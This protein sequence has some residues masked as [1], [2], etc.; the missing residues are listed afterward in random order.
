MF[1]DDINNPKFHKSNIDNK[2]TIATE[3]Q[4]TG[5]VG[6]MGNNQCTGTDT[7]SKKEMIREGYELLLNKGVKLI[8]IDG[9]MATTTWLDFLKNDK[10]KLMVVL[11]DFPTVEDN[12]ERVIQR[13]IKKKPKDELK[14][15]ESIT[16]KT[17]A[18]L[19]GKIKGFRS[20]YN[21]VI[22]Y[23]DAVL[24]LEFNDPDLSSKISNTIIQLLE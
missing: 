18:N 22:P 15:I 19:E 7:I 21:K 20:L 6:A 11:L 1:N 17:M 4:I 5:H 2:T 24:K 10:S 3:Y 16:E 23:S 12:L 14:I 13:R 9:I 8:I